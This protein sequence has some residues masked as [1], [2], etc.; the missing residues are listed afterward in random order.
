MATAPVPDVAPAQASRQ[1][2]EARTQAFLAQ[3]GSSYPALLDPEG[4]TAIAYGV[5]GVPETFF[6]DGGGRIVEKRVGSLDQ[7]TI[8]TL[9]ARVRGVVAWAVKRSSRNLAG[10]EAAAPGSIPSGL[11][12]RDTLP[13]D[14]RLA[15]AVRWTR[16]MAYGWPGGISSK[17]RSSRS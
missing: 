15:D 7:G 14:A 17:P 3:R 13:A 4:K 6:I 12:S 1:D 5:V 2:E 10:P 9:I 8:A 16:E 11:P